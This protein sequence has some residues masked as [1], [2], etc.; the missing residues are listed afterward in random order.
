M[1]QIKP[2]PSSC[3]PTL[4]T[5]IG[6]GTWN[7]LKKSKNER[8]AGIKFLLGTFA[9]PYARNGTR[10][11]TLLRAPRFKAGVSTKF[12]HTGYQQRQENR[13]NTEDGIRTRKPVGAGF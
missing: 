4:P 6:D 11:H 8:G 10:T 7:L 2:V 1:R 12:H 9:E 5:A 3:A 13:L